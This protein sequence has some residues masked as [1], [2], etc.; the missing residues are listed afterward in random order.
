ML[1]FDALD[2]LD[3]LTVLDRAVKPLAW[4]WQRALQPQDLRDAL[5]GTWLGHPLHPVL[6]QVPLGA[7]LSTN[8]L[9]ATRSDDR[10]ASLLNTVGLASAVPALAAGWAD[11]SSSNPSTQRSGLV[12]ALANVT[13]LGLWAASLVH[14]RKHNRGT[15]SLLG[16]LGSGAMAVGGAIGG[17]LAYR[18]GLGANTQADIADTA[19]TTWTDVGEDDLTDGEP[20]LVDAAG[21]PVVVV[22]AG[23]RL[24]ALADRC[25]HQAGPLHEGE[26][27]DGCLVCPWHGSTFRLTDGAVVHGPSVHPQPVFD[28][29]SEGGRIQVRLRA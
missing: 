14:R 7:L 26:F 13:G 5:H 23:G 16:L 17:H 18:D 24:L 20:V 22:R 1:P 2:K 25:T 12:H 19:P 28:A 15:A 4:F 29:R 10:A 9:D 3:D 6:V 21:T 27:E 11:W 8:A